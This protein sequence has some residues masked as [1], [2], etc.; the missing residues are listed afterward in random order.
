[1]AR[2]WT[3]TTPSLSPADVDDSLRQ[4]AGLPARRLIKNNVAAD[5]VSRPP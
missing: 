4:L 5:S 2:A 1:M 3:S